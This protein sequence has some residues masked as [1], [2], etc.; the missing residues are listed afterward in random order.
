LIPAIAITADDAIGLVGRASLAVVAEALQGAQEM[1]RNVEPSD[2]VRGFER[3]KD[4][5]VERRIGLAHGSVSF[6]LEPW[7]PF[8]QVEG[9][10]AAV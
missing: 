9:Q 8:Q 6:H 4:G 1:L 5:T 3:R 2:V 7:C 10:E